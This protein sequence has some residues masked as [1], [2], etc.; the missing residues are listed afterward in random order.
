MC[1]SLINGLFKVAVLLFLPIK[2][3]DF[4][5]GNDFAGG[6]VVPAPEVLDSPVLESGNDLGHSPEI[7]SACA[8]T[9]AQAKK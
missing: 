3:V 8:V 1:S 2:G 9:R 7:F 5:I 4:I 6:K